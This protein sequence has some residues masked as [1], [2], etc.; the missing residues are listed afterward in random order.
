MMAV[1]RSMA[2]R[3][4]DEPQVYLDPAG[5]GRFA[6]EQ[7]HRV[8]TYLTGIQNARGQVIGSP[9]LAVREQ[10]IAGIRRRPEEETAM[11][12]DGRILIVDDDE[13][14]RVLLQKVLVRQGYQVVAAGGG[15]E[16]LQRMAAQPCDLV[17]TDIRMPKMDGMALLG[18][19]RL[20]APESTVIMM[21]AFG[22]VDS[23]VEAMKQGAYRYISKPFKM[24]EVL[25]LI[26]RVAPTAATVLISA[27]RSVRSSRQMISSAILAPS[28]ACAIPIASS[29]FR[30]DFP[31]PS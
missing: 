20:V 1:S 24:D 10:S 6:G 9:E 16:A 29:R 18:Q 5:R 22:T 21:T 4:K 28:G 3:L 11:P 19:V 27:P 25:N 15:E 31:F 23:G 8:Y 14:M 12:E 2:P 7:G 26:Q 17:L 30:W 13:E